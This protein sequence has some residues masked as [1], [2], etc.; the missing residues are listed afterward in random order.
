MK[1]GRGG[2][3]A[4]S[5]P[6]TGNAATHVQ[7]CRMLAGACRRISWMA[8]QH[9][10]PVAIAEADATTPERFPRAEIKLIVG[11]AM[12]RAIR[13]AAER[14]GCAVIAKPARQR[15]RPLP[16]DLNHRRIRLQH[17]YLGRGTNSGAE[18][19]AKNRTSERKRPHSDSPTKLLVMDG[20]STA[21]LGSTDNG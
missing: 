13:T 10:I 8:A 12:V 9:A 11:A 7:P 15:L 19:P 17:G 5:N 16:I 3:L 20:A 21:T 18:S 4:A 2:S 1:S 6:F 14:I